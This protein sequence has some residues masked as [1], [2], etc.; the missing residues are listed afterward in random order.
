MQ[1]TPGPDMALVVAR[2]LGQ[3]RR[4]AFCTV[5]GFMAAGLIQVPLLVLGVASLLQASPWALDLMRW[6]GG[7]YLMWL[8]LRLMWTSRTGTGTG[9]PAPTVRSSTLGAVREGLINNLI[10]PKPVL[11]MFALLPQFVS[12]DSGSVTTQLLV[13]GLTQKATG[14][15]IQ[16]SVALASGAVGGRLGRR[17]GISMWQ[18][19][20]TGAFTVGLGLW[21]LVAGD[22]R[23]AR[24]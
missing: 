1:V 9:A 15:I 23:S 7:A 18:R 24:T 16:G 21:L 3:G 10:N 20:F 5:L 14:F 22:G 2:G 4:I 13:L 19:R 17:P 12:P 6:C 11:F 8:G